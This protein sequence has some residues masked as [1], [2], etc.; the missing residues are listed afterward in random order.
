MQTAASTPSINKIQ[1]NEWPKLLYSYMRKLDTA[2][3]FPFFQASHRRKNLVK[4]R[5][6]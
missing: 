4:K 3:I 1:N 6:W 5:D 2:C